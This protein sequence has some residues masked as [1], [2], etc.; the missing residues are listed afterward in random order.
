LICSGLRSA[1][2]SGDFRE[3]GP[4]GWPAGE[5]V[6]G[7]AS[8]YNEYLL[9][10]QR[11]LVNDDREARNGRE[12]VMERNDALSMFGELWVGPEPAPEPELSSR[13]GRC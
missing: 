10:R 6:R 9:G 11:G 8:N 2:V 3:Q 7:G 4:R 13:G 12:G 1:A 5:S